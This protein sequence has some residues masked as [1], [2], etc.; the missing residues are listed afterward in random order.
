MDS[1]MLKGLLEGCILSII[2]EKEVYG[3]EL[4]EKL[5]EAGLTMV[6]EGSIYPLLLRMQKNELIVGTMKP[7]ATGPDR[8]YYRLTAKGERALQLFDES[9]AQLYMAIAYLR[10]NRDEHQANDS[11]E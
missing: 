11:I 7:S 2:W 5:H 6:K 10:R 4:S 1:Q 9:W 3:Y 8:K